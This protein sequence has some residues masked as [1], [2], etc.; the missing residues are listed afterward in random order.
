MKAKRIVSI[1]LTGSML[2]SLPSTF[3][4]W[5]RKSVTVSWEK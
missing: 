3:H 4:R 1:L 2:L 5:L